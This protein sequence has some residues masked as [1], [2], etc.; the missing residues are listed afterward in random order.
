MY[1]HTILMDTHTVLT[2]S[3][4]MGDMVLAAEADRGLVFLLGSTGGVLM[5][6]VFAAS[7]LA[8]LMS[9]LELSSQELRTDVF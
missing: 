6:S 3:T 8:F 9:W 2:C 4:G 1:I 5:V 7:I